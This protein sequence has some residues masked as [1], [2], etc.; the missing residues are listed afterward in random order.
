MSDDSIIRLP[1]DL[2]E[3][4]EQRIASG[5]S[6]DAIEV[7]RDALAALEAEDSRRIE[8]LRARIAAALADPAPSRPST[9]VFDRADALID[10]ISRK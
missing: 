9:Q 5:G 3:R 7:I 6:A 2:A 1:A 4:V 10:S 8:A